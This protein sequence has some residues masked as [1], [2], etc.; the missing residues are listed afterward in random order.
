MDINLKKQKAFSIVEILV[1]LVVV[2]CL[3]AAMAPVITKKLKAS[4]VTVL[5]GN[6]GSETTTEAGDNGANQPETT[7]ATDGLSS[8]TDSDDNFVKV[9]L[10][11]KV[12]YAR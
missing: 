10:Q 5:G 4:S 6:G 8:V 11:T 2:S 9:L 7:T 1:A 12:D 3:T